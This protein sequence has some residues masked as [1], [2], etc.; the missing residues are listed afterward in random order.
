MNLDFEISR[1]DFTGECN[2]YENSLYLIF[3]SYKFKNV[4]S[5][6]S[7]LIS[8]H[9]SIIKRKPVQPFSLCNKLTYSFKLSPPTLN[10]SRRNLRYMIHSFTASCGKNMVYD[11]AINS[12]QPSCKQPNP[13]LVVSGGAAEG[14]KCKNGYLLDEGGNRC[15]LEED[16]GCAVEDNYYPVSDR[17]SVSLCKII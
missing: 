12:V 11:P 17:V 2:S 5:V 1:V 4:T 8:P 13:P 16:C 9:F 14:C 15:V 10:A 7:S 3:Y 6:E